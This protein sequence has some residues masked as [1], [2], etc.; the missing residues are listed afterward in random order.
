MIDLL[1]R[2]IRV[3][4]ISS[5]FRIMH[6]NYGTC[7]CCGLPWA[8]AEGHSIDMVECTDEHCGEGFFPVCEWCWQHKSFDEITNAVVS[9]YEFW[10]IDGLK[11]GYKPSYPLSE[12]LAKTRSEYERKKT[13]MT[14]RELIDKATFIGRKVSSAEI[15]VIY[16]G[17]SD[18]LTSLE[19]SQ[20]NNG[21]YY[22]SI[23]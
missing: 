7:G 14:L 21:N 12:M 5:I 4:F 2:I 18:S 10:Y 22:V 9:L 16:N 17:V 23:R 6:P 8:L 3:P 1:E 11:H 15:P 20:D 13:T 19:L